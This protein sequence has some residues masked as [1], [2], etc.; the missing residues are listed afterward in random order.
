[1]LTYLGCRMVSIRVPFRAIEGKIEAVQPLNALRW[2]VE[3]VSIG[4][5]LGP[6]GLGSLDLGGAELRD[7]MF[8]MSDV[9]SNHEIQRSPT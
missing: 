1:M 4:C 5:R 9:M 7:V 3:W 2:G 6:L 8:G